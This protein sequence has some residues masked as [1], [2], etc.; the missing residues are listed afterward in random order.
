V[1]LE[2][3]HDLA[4]AA[5]SPYAARDIDRGIKAGRFHVDDRNVALIAT[6]G[7]L[8][9]VMRAVLQGRAGRDTADHHAALV[10]RMLGLS[11]DDAAAGGRAPAS[12][13]IATLSGRKRNMSS[14]KGKPA[15]RGL[16]SLLVGSPP[17]AGGA[18]G[19]DRASAWVA[20]MRKSPPWAY[21]ASTSAPRPWRVRLP[22][23][24]RGEPSA[25]PCGPRAWPSAA[26]L[27]PRR[28]RPRHGRPAGA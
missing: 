14:Q 21:G 23:A 8:V 28:S 20:V 24:S 3:S 4:F 5:L 19:T 22:F 12:R 27:G 7:A 15:K 25:A 1:R 11:A 13:G 6:A 10:L 26:P 9:G 16:S 18:P 2:I 17:N